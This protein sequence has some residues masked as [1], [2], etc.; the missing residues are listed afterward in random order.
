M[1]QNYTLEGDTVWANLAGSDNHDMPASLPVPTGLYTVIPNIKCDQF[2]G[3]EIFG[4]TD[5]YLFYLTIFHTAQRF[6]YLIWCVTVRVG[7]FSSASSIYDHNLSL[8]NVTL[9]LEPY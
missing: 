6:T 9:T 4:G 8:I 7:V 5:A 2:S 3:T 1:F